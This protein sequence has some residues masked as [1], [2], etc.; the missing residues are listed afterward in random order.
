LYPSV[1]KLQVFREIYEHLIKERDKNY[2][3]VAEYFFEAQQKYQIFASF[4]AIEKDYTETQQNILLS[5]VKDLQQD[6]E[7]PLF[8]DDSEY[9]VHSKKVERILFE[10]DV[11]GE[12]SKFQQQLK[13]ADVKDINSIFN[14]V[15][16]LISGLHKSKNKVLHTEASTSGLLYG[17]DSVESLREMYSQ[18]VEQK[19]EEESVYYTLGYD[20]FKDVKMVRG[21][22]VVIGGFTSHGKSLLLRNIIYHLLTEYKLNCYYCSLEMSYKQMK[23]LFLALH[24]NNQNIFKNHIPIKYEDIKEGNLTQEQYDFLFNVVAPDLFTNPEYGTLFLE[25]P[26]KTKYRLS[27]VRSKIVELENTKMPIHAAAIDYITMLYPLESEKKMPTREDYNQMIKEFK[28]MALSHRRRDGN[29]APFLA[30]TPA[31]ISRGGLENAIKNNNYYDLSALR[32]Y[33]ELESSADVVLTTMLTQD[34]RQKQQ[35]R[36]QN[37]KNRDGR[38]ETE[39]YDLFCDLDFGFMISDNEPRTTD[40]KILAAKMFNL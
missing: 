36:M 14:P 18:I 40:E 8:Q 20:K 24:A 6:I 38:V 39:A 13:T 4:S 37:L 2:D 22:L 16:D 5:Y 11:F 30:L 17:E 32:E 29:P 7:I 35:I 12:V 15:D 19:K 3:A 21:N 34:L 9:V 27:D 28:N 26:N 10:T 1:A 33:S 23:L 31:Q 25:Y